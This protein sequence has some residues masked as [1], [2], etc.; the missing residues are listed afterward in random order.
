MI[1]TEHSVVVVLYFDPLNGYGEG[2]GDK[3]EES[4][5]KWGRTRGWDLGVTRVGTL[6]IS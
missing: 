6:A 1:L 2:K 5:S 3:L 4:I